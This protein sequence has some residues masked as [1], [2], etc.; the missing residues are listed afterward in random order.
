MA[1]TR[2]GYAMLMLGGKDIKQ[3]LNLHRRIPQ[4]PSPTSNT[5]P[6]LECQDG[7]LHHR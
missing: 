7:Q 4:G 3:T 5:S 2:I 1:A 6:V